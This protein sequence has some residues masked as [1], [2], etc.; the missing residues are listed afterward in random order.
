MELSINGKTRQLNDPVNSLAHYLRDH[1]RIT[2]EEKGVAVALNGY[3]VPK[4][5]WADTPLAQGDTLE[6]VRA[7]QGG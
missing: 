4:A 1:E 5:R 3:V 7:F 2:P 6:I